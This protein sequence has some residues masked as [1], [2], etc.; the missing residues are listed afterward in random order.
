M[1]FS[2]LWI[3]IKPNQW[4]LLF[5]LL[6]KSI[7]NSIDIINRRENT[8]PHLCLYSSYKNT[9]N[10][11][12]WKHLPYKQQQRMEWNLS[13]PNTALTTTTST[14]A[15]NGMELVQSK[16]CLNNNN[17]NNSIEWN[18]TCPIQTLLTKRIPLFGW[19]TDRHLLILSV[20]FA[21]EI[22]KK[23]ENISNK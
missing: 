18:G 3:G 21:M 11:S 14:T 17:I 19:L 22:K 5:V 2:Y 7:W 12:Q 20:K 13:N 1:Y 4:I 9:F 6:I 23:K 10:I 8:W 16:H 15:S